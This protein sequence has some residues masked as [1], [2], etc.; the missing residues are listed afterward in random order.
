MS[1]WIIALIVCVMCFSDVLVISALLAA[2]ASN[3]WN[4]LADKYPPVP[5]R[6][7][8][9][10]REFQSFGFGFFNVGFCVHVTVDDQAM[11][12]APAKL[13]R[14]AK[15]RP[16]SI[17]WDAITLRNKDTPPKETGTLR[18]TIAKEDVKGP[19]WCLRL[20]YKFPIT[21]VHSDQRQ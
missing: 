15:C 14:W 16:M 5:V 10:T 13:L 19:A 21:E 8:S 18:A 3:T 2:F 12:L 1:P 6:E 9:I 20:A 17:P 7:P 4:P 11:H